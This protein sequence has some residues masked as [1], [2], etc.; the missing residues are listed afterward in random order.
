VG[1]SVGLLYAPTARDQVEYQDDYRDHDQD[2]NKI[3]PEVTDESQQPQNQE[4]HQYCPQHYFIL[5]C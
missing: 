4:D 3:S 1:L 2:V 5:L